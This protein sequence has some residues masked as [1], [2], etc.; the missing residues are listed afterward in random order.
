M[1][2]PEWIARLIG[3]VAVQPLPE[4]PAPIPEK[5]KTMP[6][7]SY[8]GVVI[9][10]STFPGKPYETIQVKLNSY[11][12]N[13]Y[14]PAMEK[15]CGGK[16]KG[17]KLLITAMAH[18]EGFK[19][20]SRSYRTKNPGNIGNTDSGANKPAATLEEGV[21]RQINYIQ[22]IVDGKSKVYP[23]NKQ[24]YLPP[25]YSKEI[26]ANP[27]AY[28]VSDG[29][30]PGYKFTFTGQI[31]QFV[32][33]YATFP[34]INQTYVNTIVSFFQQNGLT[35]SPQSKIQDIISIS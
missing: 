34:R 15:V 17:L 27:K 4:T 31:D 25:F 11:M 29:N 35:I 26:N 22:R 9:E 23:M 19:P 6:P 5:P 1:K 10:G 21:Q 14:L 33:I 13:E 30:V 3:R 8:K 20:G 16:P 2:M 12:V 32:K 24:V 18:I 28:G 7:T